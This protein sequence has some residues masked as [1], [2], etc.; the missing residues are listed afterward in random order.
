[1]MNMTA[2]NVAK[3]Q[4]DNIDEGSFST[5]TIQKKNEII[6]E[7]V[8][9]KRNGASV[10]RVRSKTLNKKQTSKKHFGKTVEQMASVKQE[11]LVDENS[12]AVRSGSLAQNDTN[13]PQQEELK[14]SKENQRP[15][16]VGTRERKRAGRNRKKETLKNENDTTAKNAPLSKE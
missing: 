5:R 15:T 6:T 7:E 1:M 13:V 4:E 10:A 9:D 2:S 11:F 3:N 12:T 8:V 14:I 16:E